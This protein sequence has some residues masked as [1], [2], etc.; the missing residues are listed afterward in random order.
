MSVVAAGAVLGTV[1]VDR[2]GD[3]GPDT[4]LAAGLLAT[5]AVE[6]PTVA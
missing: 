2:V 4:K 6:G 3:A 5:V 1:R